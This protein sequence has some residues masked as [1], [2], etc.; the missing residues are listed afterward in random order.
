[1]A[2]GDGISVFQSLVSA[3]FVHRMRG[4]VKTAVRRDE[5]IIPEGYRRS[6]QN[7]AVIIGEEI[8]SDGYIITVIT[9]EGGAD[10]TGLASPSQTLSHHLFP[11]SSAGGQYPIVLKAL[12]L[13]FLHLPSQLLIVIGIIDHP[14][15]TLFLFCHR[16]SRR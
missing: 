13:S 10:L 6:I 3:P 15:V 12:I 2:H 9:P 7:H 14:G 8:L 5:Y 11:F 1:M 4:R 16:A